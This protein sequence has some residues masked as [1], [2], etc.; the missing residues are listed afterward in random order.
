MNKYA[1]MQRYTER[2]ETHNRSPLLQA[3]D[4]NTH[5]SKVCDVHHHNYR[6][7]T[8][9]KDHKHGRHIEDTCELCRLSLDIGDGRRL[10]MSARHPHKV[11]AR[12]LWMRRKTRCQ[13]NMQISRK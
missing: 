12:D 7:V 5:N 6:H 3:R 8:C 4:I 13:R 1:F 11:R 9:N 10:R 2:E